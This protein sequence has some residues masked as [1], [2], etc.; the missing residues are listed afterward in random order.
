MEQD[1]SRATVVALGG[2]SSFL[3]I[4][5]DL[6][7]GHAAKPTSESWLQLSAPLDGSDETRINRRGD[8]RRSLS[9]H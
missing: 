1:I 5:K 4:I 3:N 6:M 7:I 9:L 8:H 2:M